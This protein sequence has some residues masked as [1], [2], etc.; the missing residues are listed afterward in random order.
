MVLASSICVIIL[1]KCHFLE[2]SVHNIFA[3]VFLILL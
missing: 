1:N 2:W 3:P